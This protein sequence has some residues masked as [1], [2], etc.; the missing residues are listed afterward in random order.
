M[1]ACTLPEPRTRALLADYGELRI[2]EARARWV[3][4]RPVE[5][6]PTGADALAAIAEL[7]QPGLAPAE[8]LARVRAARERI[9]KAYQAVVAAETIGALP[10]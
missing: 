8:L 6:L 7:T 3:T 9:R 10:A 1:L 5:E 4:G 2:V